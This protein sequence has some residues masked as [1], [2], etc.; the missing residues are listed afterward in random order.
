MRA[1]ES[2]H[3]LFKIIIPAGHDSSRNQTTTI[4]LNCRCFEIS[5]LFFAYLCLS[6]RLLTSFGSAYTTQFSISHHNYMQNGAFVAN[7][8]GFTRW[9]Y[10][11]MECGWKMTQ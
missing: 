6:L 2:S 10:T 9:L 11:E 4:S 5:Y 1:Q 3:D 8:I 7:Y